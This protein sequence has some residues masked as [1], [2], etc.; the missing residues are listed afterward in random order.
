M[1]DV[2]SQSSTE[3]LVDQDKAHFVHPWTIFDVFR[4]EGAL[5]IARAE[6]PFI[7]DTNGKRY[8][9]AV[10]GLW[11]TNI[12][13]GRREMADAI[14][15][16]VMDMT[17]ANPFVDMTNIPAT[18]LAAKLAELAPGDLNRVMFTSGGS[19]AVDSAF[20]LIHYY[21][22]CRGKHEKKH[23]ISRIS[24]YHGSTYASMS[25]GG[26]K[27]DHPPEF[28]YITET[29]HHIS[30]PNPYRPPAGME[31]L[32]G[33]EL[34]DALVKEFEDKIAEI[35]GA[36]KV[37]AFFA[38]PIMGAGGVIVPPGNYIRQMW[39]VCQKHDILYVSD[40]VVTA[41]GRLGH[42]FASKD[43]FDIEPDI[44]TCAKGLTS[45]YQPLGATIFSDR[46]YDVIG[47]KGHDRCFA[48]GF[49]YSGHPVACAAAL[50]NLEIMEREDLLSHV[51]EI[52]PYFNEQLKTLLDL[53]IVGDVRGHQL[54]QC[55]EFVASKETKEL[56]PEELDIGKVVSN[57]AD[58]RGLM[59]RP[60]I[61][62]NIMSP[63]LIITREN[64]D[65]I[66][67]TLR[68]SIG[69]AMEELQYNC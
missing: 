8:L 14:A 36:E 57:H 58:E 54:M 25:I 3:E 62:L 7:Y 10:G 59:V 24:S 21:Q 53:P 32:S 35:G 1:S 13:L 44:I 67:A 33:R 41:F 65:F 26:K 48:H 69:A 55:V 51:S 52:G 43:V 39:E 47:E 18:R 11:C 19:T 5:P 27:G 6:G 29:I 46:I 40:E 64:I 9:D 16:Q 34:V 56:F 68:E 49:T 45:G 17:Y 30:C 31:N 22:N 38:E 28:D 4:E 66:V 12:G 37:A 61:N 50:K 42:W 63:S 60:I 23:I 2:S 20:R 15:E